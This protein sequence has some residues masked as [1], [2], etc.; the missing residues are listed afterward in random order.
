MVLPVSRVKIKSNGGRR[1]LQKHGRRIDDHW[2]DRNT[3]SLRLRHMNGTTTFD[4]AK[5]VNKAIAI[6]LNR[7]GLGVTNEKTHETYPDST[8][9]EMNNQYLDFS[10]T[11]NL[12]KNNRGFFDLDSWGW[13]TKW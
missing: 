7:W 9:V 12:S 5:A 11:F 8:L 6:I 4:N 1:N 13:D 10:Y 2:H 3:G